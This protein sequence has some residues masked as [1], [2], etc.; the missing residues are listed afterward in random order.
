MTI[1]NIF[2]DGFCEEKI[3]NDTRILHN[4][5]GERL[6]VLSECTSLTKRG[7]R[8]E[9]YKL[10]VIILI[11]FGFKLKQKAFCHFYTVQSFLSK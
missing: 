2:A 3:M 5:Y 8:L 9:V 1:E 11:R 4:A 7:K 10:Q 6:F